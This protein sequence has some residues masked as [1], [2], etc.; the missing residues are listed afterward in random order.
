MLGIWRKH[1]TIRKTGVSAVLNAEKRATGPKLVLT[2]LFVLRAKT[3]GERT[4][5]TK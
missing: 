3:V 1:A 4:L 5:T 2:N